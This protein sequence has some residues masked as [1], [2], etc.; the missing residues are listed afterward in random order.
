MKIGCALLRG[1]NRLLTLTGTGGIGKTRMGL[2]IA[3][4][5]VDT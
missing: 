3:T 5:L 4:E 1:D 2:A